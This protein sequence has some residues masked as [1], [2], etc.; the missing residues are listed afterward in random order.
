MGQCRCNLKEKLECSKERFNIKYPEAV[1]DK[2]FVESLKS[3]SEEIFFVLSERL[4]LSMERT[5]QDLDRIDEEKKKTRGLFSKNVL[6]LIMI[7]F[8]LECDLT[9]DVNVSLL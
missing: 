1:A 5:H 3:R 4:A 8:R 6:L 2:R 9:T 7:S